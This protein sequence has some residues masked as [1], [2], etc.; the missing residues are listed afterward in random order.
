MKTLACLVA[1]GA[2]ALSAALP[3]LDERRYHLRSGSNAEWEEFAAS[4][5]HGKRLDVAFSAPSNATEYTLLLWQDD[6]K[7]DWRGELNGKRVGTL[8][9]MEA[10]LDFALPLPTGSLKNGSNVLSIIPPG[11]NDDIRV[12]DIRLIPQP[13]KTALSESTV[14]VEVTD[15]E[16]GRASPCRLTIA[17]TNDTLA[18]LMAPTNQVVAVRPGVVYTGDGRALVH[19]RAGNYVVSATRGF[20]FSLATSHITMAAGE[21]RVVRLQ[22][23]RDVQTHGLVTCDTH[24]H[25][26]TYSRH[27]DASV[28]ERAITL[29]GEGIELAIAT[30]HDVAVDLQPAASTTR[31]RSYFTPVIGDEVTTRVGHFNIFPVAAGAKL[32]GNR[33]TNWTTLLDSFRATPGVQVVVF[34][35]PRN[36]HTGFQPFARTNFNR[37]TGEARW[38]FD[39][40]FDAMELINSSAMQSDFM[41]VFNDWFALLNAGHRITAVGS[42]DGHDVSRYIVGQGRTYI[43]CDDKNPGALDVAAACESLKSGRAY[44]SLGLLPMMRI[45]DRFSVGDL[46]TN[47]GPTLTIKVP[48]LA[49]SWIQCDR[50]ELFSNG[51]SIRTTNLSEISTRPV[52]GVAYEVEWTVPRPKQDVFLVVIATGPGVTAPHWPVS[53]PYQSSSPRW[54]PLVIGATNPIR[55]D[56]DGDGKFSSARDYAR[57]L[58]NIAKDAQQLVESL[59]EYDDA[60]AIQAAALARQRGFDLASPEFQKAFSTNPALRRAFAKVMAEE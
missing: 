17:H 41:S 11:E 51:V 25:T 13:L 59:R 42:S 31:T 56:A 40:R 15:S 21:R 26:F 14:E 44:V 5:P 36:L 20:E 55:I 24:V 60:V 2:L 35:H 43:E 57:R 58:V 29:A 18:A 38:P 39:F 1:F 52:A 23:R 45:N 47:V 19:L 32:P 27:G 46:A 49:P 8:F 9:A 12:G 48:V 22:L 4:Q 53:K 54:T 37:I 10:P 30:D 7:L 34:N 3:T 28:E 33:E 6:V 16:S 50:V